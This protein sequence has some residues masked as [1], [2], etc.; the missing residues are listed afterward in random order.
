MRLLCFLAV[1]TA[2]FL[3][4]VVRAADPPAL[5]PGVYLSAAKA[6]PDYKVQ[7]EYKGALLESETTAI[8]WGLQVVALGDGAFEAV[9]LQG[10]LPGDGWYS[11]TRT[12]LVSKPGSNPVVLTGEQHNRTYR[13]DDGWITAL[14]EAGEELGQLAK[15]HRVSPSM[16]MSPPPGAVV[17]F[18]GKESDELD[19]EVVTAEGLLKQGFITRRPVG[20]FRLHLEFRTPFMPTFRGQQ[21]GNSGVYIQRRYEVQILDSFGLEGIE[22]EAG[23]LYRQ[24]RADINMALPPLQW[25]TYDIHFRAA[26][27]KDGKRIKNARITVMQNGVAVQDDVKIATKTG[28]GRAEGPDPLPIQFQDHRDQVR[29]RNM[30]IV[31]D[32]I[33]EPE[34]MTAAVQNHSHHGGPATTPTVSH[35]QLSELQPTSQPYPPIA[36][37]VG[38]Q[39]TIYTQPAAP[40]SCQQHHYHQ[41]QPVYGQSPVYNQP[42][43]DQPVFQHTPVEYPLEFQSDTAPYGTAPYD[44][45]PLY[46]DPS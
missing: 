21:R 16:G 17:L 38:P 39:P 25:Q 36:Y 19:D 7:G 2:P 42:V 44:A 34:Q 1:A 8:T 28:A 3:A 20:D 32:D 14:N 43:Y 30:W 46:A 33:G 18:D 31:L 35:T 40:C 11:Q 10:G 9:L 45:A 37:S 26:R 41:S 23:A 12:K 6:G 29:F 24:R 13:V 27:F 15:V 22:N 4:G 5:R